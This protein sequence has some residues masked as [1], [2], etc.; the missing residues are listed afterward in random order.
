MDKKHAKL[1]L[2]VVAKAPVPGEVKTRLVPQFSYEEAAGL[3]R[4]F[5]Q[6]RMMTMKALKGLD[7]AIAYTPA[8]AGDMFVPFSQNGIGLFP[9]KGGD[10][11]ERLN[12]IFLDKLAGGYNAVSIIDSD[13]PDLPPWIIQESFRR[14]L[15]GQFDVV[16]G[17][18]HDGGY[19]L[20]GMRKPHPDLFEDIPWS[21]ETVL[22][23]TLERAGKRG[24]KT[25]LL[26]QWNDLDTFEDLAA[27]YK[28]HKN[29]RPKGEWSGKQ[30]FLFL[31]Q[32]TK[33]NKSIAF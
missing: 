8:D 30:T 19:Y 33:I 17:P 31:S 11:G 1:L 15:S 16:L 2:V 28:K 32:L 20:I 27:Y 23:D 3:Y 22:S 14:L 7:L 26:L 12:N 9:Q 18:C 13:T 25:D 6:D 21:T 24:V 5:L 10:L 29:R 4:R